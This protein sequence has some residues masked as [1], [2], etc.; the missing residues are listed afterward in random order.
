MNKMVFFHGILTT[1]KEDFIGVFMS[2]D[3]LSNVQKPCWLIGGY[4]DGYTVILP[5]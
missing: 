4:T 2:F 5:W 3:L 1:K